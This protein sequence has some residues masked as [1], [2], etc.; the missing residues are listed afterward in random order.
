MNEENFSKF[1][2]IVEEYL[3]T[4]KVFVQNP[5]RMQDVSAATEIA[6]WLF[7]DA[8]IELED[9]PLQMGSI[10]LSITDFGIPVRDTK[11]FADLISN[12][13][14]FDI[15]AAGNDLVRI[16]ILFRGALTRIG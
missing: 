16:S 6:C 12:A 5:Q 7:P 13:N 15:Y 8:A 2:A 11:Q 3:E 1:A 9:D 4:Q 10:I 14:N